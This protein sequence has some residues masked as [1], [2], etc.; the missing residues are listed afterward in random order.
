ME[1]KEIQ[2]FLIETMKL[3]PDRAIFHY[4]VKVIIHWENGGKIRGSLG[5]VSNTKNAA[6]TA[7]FRHINSV[8]AT[9]DY[10]KMTGVSYPISPNDYLGIMYR[11]YFLE[12]GK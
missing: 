5:A 10:R 9:K 3:K 1:N 2:A 7:L 11:L 12:R 6:N 8:V 4:L